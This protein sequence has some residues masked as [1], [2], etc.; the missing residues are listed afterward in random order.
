MKINLTSIGHDE[1]IAYEIAHKDILL[2]AKYPEAFIDG[3]LP[4]IIQNPPPDWLPPTGK[5]RSILSYFNLL[6]V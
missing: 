6:L 4:P 1:N 2:K 5:K 3:D